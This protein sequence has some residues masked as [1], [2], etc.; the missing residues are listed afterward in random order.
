MHHASR[1]RKS[2]NAGAQVAHENIV[3]RGEVK[4]IL[5]DQN[6]SV[7]LLVLLLAATG[8]LIWWGLKLMQG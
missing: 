6:R 1:S 8:S 2:R 3:S 7:A 4:N 5:R